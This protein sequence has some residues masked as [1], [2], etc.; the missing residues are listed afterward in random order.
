VSARRDVTFVMEEYNLTE[1]HACKLLDLD[2]ATFRYEAAP[3]RN[4]KLRE[5]L[6][7]LARQKPRYGYRRLAALL[8]RRSEQ[9]PSVNRV[10]R[11]Y[12]KEHLEVRR[13]KRKRVVRSTPADTT[14]TG[15][16][17]EWAIDFVYDSV[18]TGRGIRCLT[19]VDT[20]TRECPV[21]EVATSLG[22]Q[23]VT[24]ALERVM[25]D[26]GVPKAVRCDNGPEFTSRHFVSWCEGK[27]VALIHSRMHPANPSVA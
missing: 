26:R 17:Q 20:F 16:N 23:S 12:R 19:V 22:S 27:G 25:L 6:V 9:K 2:R 24:R 15:P 4:A 13:R 18:S 5:E 21:I 14:L 3:D 7:A 8:A 1:R 11:L 10:H